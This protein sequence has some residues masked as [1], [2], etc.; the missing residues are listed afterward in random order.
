MGVGRQSVLL[1]CCARA[2]DEWTGLLSPRLLQFGAIGS[3]VDARGRAGM[4]KT[5]SKGGFSR[6]AILDSGFLHPGLSNA[7]LIKRLKVPGPARLCAWRAL[8]A[9]AADCALPAR[10]AQ[11]VTDTLENYGDDDDE[12]DK[13]KSGE[14]LG[15]DPGFQR[16]PLLCVQ[17]HA[18]TPRAPIF[19][20]Q[21]HS[22]FPRRWVRTGYWSTRTRTSVFSWPVRLRTCCA[23]SR[24]SRLT[25][26]RRMPT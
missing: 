6:A 2:A 20:P 10:R 8:L 19:W 1:R 25:R 17:S 7:D 18:L 13:A 22:I 4:Q 26:R 11:A 9:Q 21:R 16:C 15:R 24:L 23:F 5:A 3:L 14:L 12:V